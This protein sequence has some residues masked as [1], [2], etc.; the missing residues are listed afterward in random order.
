MKAL[1][2]ELVRRT[3][4]SVYIIGALT[5]ALCLVAGVRIWDAFSVYRQ[6]ADVRVEIASLQSRVAAL[7][8]LRIRADSGG[9]I[10]RRNNFA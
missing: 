3:P 1:R 10:R 9:S 8:G 6:T 4:I 7:N 5:F 2:V